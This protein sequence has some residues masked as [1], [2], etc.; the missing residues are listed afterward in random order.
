MIGAMLVMGLVMAFI[1]LFI[2]FVFVLS[3]RPEKFD[4]A[5]FNKYDGTPGGALKKKASI[6][7]WSRVYNL[8]PW[9]E[10]DKMHSMIFS[11]V[12][13]IVLGMLFPVTGI[14]A[15]FGAVGSTVV[16]QPLYTMLRLKRQHEAWKASGGT[17]S[18]WLMAHIKAMFRALFMRL[19]ATVTR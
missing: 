17:Y 6:A 13:S 18:G 8:G 5:K 3:L 1:E 14:I 10:A 2:E 15:F 12:M 16:G 7:I 19:K 11:I 4:P 9:L